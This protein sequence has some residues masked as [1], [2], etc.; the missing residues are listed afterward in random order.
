M[1]YVVTGAVRVSAGQVGRVRVVAARALAV[2]GDGDHVRI[3]GLEPENRFLLIAGKSLHEPVAR[4]G[5]FVMNTRAEV[6]QAFRDY[7]QGD[8]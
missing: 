5:P 8:L 3:I 6:L 2:L 7:E 4:G 1:L